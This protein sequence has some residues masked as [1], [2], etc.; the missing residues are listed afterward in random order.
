MEWEKERACTIELCICV[1]CCCWN[2]QLSWSVGSGKGTLA[3]IVAIAA[4]IAG[5]RAGCRAVSLVV[6]HCGQSEKKCSALLQFRGKN[7]NWTVNFGL[8]LL[9]SGVLHSCTGI[10]WRRVEWCSFEAEHR[11]KRRENE[12]NLAC[13]SKIWLRFGNQMFVG[14][15]KLCW[16]VKMLLV[17]NCCVGERELKTMVGWRGCCWFGELL[18]RIAALKL[19]SSRVNGWLVVFLITVEGGSRVAMKVGDNWNRAI[20]WRF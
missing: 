7:C 5:Q 1:G 9:A 4:G 6:Y 20:G 12:G 19:W 15:E 16:G 2:L 8:L 18:S 14:V 3:G 10:V 13:W 17:Y 11:L